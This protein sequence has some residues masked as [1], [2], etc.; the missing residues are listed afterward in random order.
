[1]AGERFE[2]RMYT[3]WELMNRI[4]SKAW[5]VVYVGGCFVFMPSNYTTPKPRGGLC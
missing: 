4:Q 1:M 3:Y 5:K 2:V